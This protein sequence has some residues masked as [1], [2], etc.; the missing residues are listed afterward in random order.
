MSSFSCV[1]VHVY[2]EQYL[3]AAALVFFRQRFDVGDALFD[4]SAL[5]LVELYD[6]HHARPGGFQIDFGGRDVHAV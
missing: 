3:L 2:L 1:S 6:F 5:E 4:R